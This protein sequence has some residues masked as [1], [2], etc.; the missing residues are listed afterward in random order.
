MFFSCIYLHLPFLRLAQ[1]L[2]FVF[3]SWYSV[4]YSASMVFHCAPTGLWH[5][6]FP[7]SFLTAFSPV[8]FLLS[9]YWTHFSSPELSSLFHS[10]VCIFLN[11]NKR[12]PYPAQPA[13][14][15]ACRLSKWVLSAFH[16][17]LLFLGPW[18]SIQQY[19]SSVISIGHSSC[20]LLP[21]REPRLSTG[22]HIR[23]GF[24]ITCPP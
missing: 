14:S 2:C 5:F 15:C 3:Q 21:V 9:L 10:T 8:S 1:F 20:P 11:F 4:L 6:S 22:L 16:T 23:W 18:A 19:G 17:E 24:Y 12:C 7:C 13:R